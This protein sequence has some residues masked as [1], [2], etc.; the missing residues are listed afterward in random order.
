[1]L[2]IVETVLIALIGGSLFYYLHTPLPWMLGALA[3]VL[4]WSWLGKRK[5]RWPVHFANIGQVIIG[6]TIGRTFTQETCQQILNQ[7]PTMLLVTVVTVLFSLMMGYITHKKTG[8]TIETGL[9]GSIP[10][11]LTQVAVLCREVPGTDITV[12][13]LMQT[14]RLLSVVFVVP[15]LA[16]HGLGYGGDAVPLIQ[17]STAQAVNSYLPTTQILLVAGLVIVSAML[18]WKL[19]LPTPFLLGSVIGTAVISLYSLPVPNV[20]QI[21][22]D[23]AQ[24]CIGAYT[25]ARIHLEN[26]ENW[27]KVLPYTMLG[28]L[29]LII[30]SLGIGFVLMHVTH[31]SL[32]TAFL[33]TAPGGMAEMGLT[34][35]LLHADLSA[36]IAFQLFRLLFILMVLPPILKWWLAKTSTQ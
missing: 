25:G 15:F 14:A 28:V 20:P 16:V 3:A 24:L 12:V 2:S 8:I 9:I 17:P 23:G 5:V 6:Y 22:L 19:R 11:G 29:G 21:Y 7:L 27:R 1:L 32:V 33:S 35:M 36:I 34:A 31:I 18:A 26:L 10:G 30:C 13:T 4:L